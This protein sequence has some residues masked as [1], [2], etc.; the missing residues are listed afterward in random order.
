MRS[1]N[2]RKIPISEVRSIINTLAILHPD[3]MLSSALDFSLLKT[4]HDLAVQRHFVSLETEDDW[5]E[6]PW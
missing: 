6:V 5:K 4:F 3:L 2:P 1:L